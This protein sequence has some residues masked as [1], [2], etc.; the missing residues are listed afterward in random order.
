[1]PEHGFQ[2]DEV[3]VKLGQKATGEFGNNMFAVGKAGI[4]IE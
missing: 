4:G 2:G 1:L 3:K